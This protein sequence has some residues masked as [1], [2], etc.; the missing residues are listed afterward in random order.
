LALYVVYPL[1]EIEPCV[2]R[3]WSPKIPAPFWSTEEI[4]SATVPEDEEELLL[5]VEVML[6]DEV[7]VLVDVE[8]D[9]LELLELLDEEPALTMI[10]PCIHEWNVQW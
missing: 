7:V 2:T 5:V 4:C 6:V 1:L 3:V 8:L 10:V 9:V